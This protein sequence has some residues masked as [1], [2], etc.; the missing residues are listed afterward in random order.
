MGQREDRQ[1]E[2]GMPPK[3]GGNGGEKAVAFGRKRTTLH[4]DRRMRAGVT[5]WSVP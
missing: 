4:P 1:F 3:R 5:S 2:C